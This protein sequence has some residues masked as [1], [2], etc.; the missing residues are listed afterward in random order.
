MDAPDLRPL[1]WAL[2]IAGILTGGALTGGV[3]GILY[4]VG[5]L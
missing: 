4:A 5:V 3:I 1:F 2:F